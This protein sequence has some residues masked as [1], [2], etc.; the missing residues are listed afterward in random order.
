MPERIRVS[1][2]Y[3][4]LHRHIERE[5][6]VAVGTTV[7]DAIRL[8]SIRKDLPASFTPAA[9]AVFGRKAGL[10]TRVHDGDRIE[11]CR[12]LVID[13]KQ[14]RRRRAQTQP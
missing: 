4:D 6:D 10:A 7:E 9:I 12:P 8:S 2:V 5:V 3:A 14:A 11:M 1:V 13:P